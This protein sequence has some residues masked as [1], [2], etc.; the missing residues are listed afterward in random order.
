MATQYFRKELPDQPLRL[1]NGIPLTG[2]FFAVDDPWMQNELNTAI[3]RR[4]GGILSISKEEYDDGMAQKKSETPQQQPREFG[5]HNLPSG[6]SRPAAPADTEQ[7]KVETPPPLQ[8]PKFKPRTGK[9]P[10]VAGE[11]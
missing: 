11:Q 8:V 7:K 6:Q 9:A 4:V 2:E 1:S 10:V 5:L 3:T